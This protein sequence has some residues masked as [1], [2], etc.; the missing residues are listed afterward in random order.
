MRIRLLQMLLTCC[1]IELLRRHPELAENFVAAKEEEQD[2]NDDDY[3]L[4]VRYNISMS[5]VSILIGLEHRTRDAF[6]RLNQYNVKTNTDIF[7]NLDTLGLDD[8]K[9]NIRPPVNPGPVYFVMLQN[10]R[11]SNVFLHILEELAHQLGYPVP[12]SV[13][14]I[15]STAHE[16][17]PDLIGV[18]SHPID[19]SFVS[20]ASQAYVP[21]V[22]SVSTGSPLPPPASTPLTTPRTPRTPAATTSASP[23]R[24]RTPKS[25]R[26]VPIILEDLFRPVEDFGLQRC[27]RCS[28]K[29]NPR[30]CLVVCVIPTGEIEKANFLITACQLCKKNKEKCSL[31]TRV[32]R[33]DKDFLETAQEQFDLRTLNDC[34]TGKYRVALYTLLVWF[35]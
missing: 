34:T 29:K 2:W 8:G 14:G 22:S 11:F 10:F 18:D 27:L 3:I 16:Q 23:T 24:K 33:L 15:M 17:N 19:D 7:Y 32:G 20:P 25:S 30:P 4:A 21:S 28:S 31:A 5:F 9:R 12:P 6:A 13:V 35:F 26:T 1:G